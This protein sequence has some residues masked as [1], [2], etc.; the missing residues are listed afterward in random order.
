MASKKVAVEPAVAVESPYLYKKV[1][2]GFSAVLERLSDGATFKIQSREAKAARAAG[3]VEGWEPKDDSETAS[4]GK[5]PK[6][7]KPPRISRDETRTVT[8]AAQAGEYGVILGALFGTFAVASTH[9]HWALSTD[10]QKLLGDA[11]AGVMPTL[12][13]SVVKR[14]TKAS[15]W[16]KLSL[17]G[18]QIMGPRVVM[19]QSIV[20]AQRALPKEQREPKSPPTLRP[21]PNGR[22][23]APS[24]ADVAF[25]IPVDPNAI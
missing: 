25:P 14:M 8:R 18:V 12:P 5:P 23:E 6:R 21:V 19:S 2:S 9:K 24:V 17:V 10:E 3:E 1:G 22:A 7:G 11:V 20:A 4:I 13:A 16:I 15:P